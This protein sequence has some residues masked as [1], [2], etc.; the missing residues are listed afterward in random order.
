MEEIK[1]IEQVGAEVPKSK[2][3]RPRQK[4]TGEYFEAAFERDESKARQKH[5]AKEVQVSFSNP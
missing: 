4:L 2:A 3:G 1:D 5:H